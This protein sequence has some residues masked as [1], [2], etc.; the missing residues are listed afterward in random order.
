MRTSRSASVGVVTEGVDVHATLSVGIVAGDV[1]CDAGR[2]GFGL[3]LEGDGALDGGLTT[4][5]G[6]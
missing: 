5:D 6:D 1:P 3:L 2:A 4:D